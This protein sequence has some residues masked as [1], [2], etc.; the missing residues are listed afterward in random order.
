MNPYLMSLPTV[1]A[2]LIVLFFSLRA[3]CEARIAD[4]AHKAEHEKKMAEFARQRAEREAAGWKLPVVLRVTLD[5]ADPNSEV[6]ILRTTLE[7]GQLVTRMSESETASGGRGLFL[8]EA[9]I[10]PGSVRLT[11]SPVEYIGSAE[12]VRRIAEEWNA[13]GGPLPPGVTSAHADVTAA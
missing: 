1:T 12:R 13:H 2:A 4:A 5:L 6:D 8:T 3:L 9:K 11:L 7:A 10:E